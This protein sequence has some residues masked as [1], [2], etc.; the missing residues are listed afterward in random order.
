MK[1]GFAFPLAL[2]T[3]V[4]LSVLV[5]L[6][7]S[8]FVRHQQV[9]SAWHALDQAQLNTQNA[10]HAFQT[11]NSGYRPQRLQGQ[12]EFQPGDG[13]AYQAMPWGLHWLVV[14]RG[15]CGNQSLRAWGVV[16]KTGKHPSYLSVSHATHWDSQVT[17]EGDLLME[18]SSIHPHSKLPVSPNTFWSDTRPPILTSKELGNHLQAPFKN[19]WHQQFRAFHAHA[20]I[21]RVSQEIDLTQLPQTI[22]LILLGDS[23]TITG[24]Y[25]G[26]GPLVIAAENSLKTFGQIHINNA[27]VLARNRLV[28]QDSLRARNTHFV[29]S[30]IS[31]HAPTDFEGSMVAY[32]I[33][34]TLSPKLKLMGKGIAKGCF[35]A[36]RIDDVEPQKTQAL[37]QKGKFIETTGFL[38]SSGRMDVKGRHRGSLQTQRFIHHDQ[39]RTVSDWVTDFQWQTTPWVPLPWSFQNGT[40]QFQSLQLTGEVQ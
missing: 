24:H 36:L 39:Q 22:P 30:Q 14:V 25:A 15:Y 33:G 10:L 20:E 11:W 3:I 16:G 32:N 7:L 17:L 9:T 37:L 13:F 1:N 38:Y 26:T 19:K 35:L 28:V 34:K 12:F 8:L 23:I 31:V 4:V 5:S 2:G 40:P 18:P 21:R 27:L 6:A 29:A